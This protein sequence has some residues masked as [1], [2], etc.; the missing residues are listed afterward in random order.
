MVKAVT[1]YRLLSLLFLIAALALPFAKP[2][3]LHALE[4]NTHYDLI[5]PP[6]PHSG[7]MPTV[8]EVFNFKCSHCYRLHPHMAAW[9][10][11]NGENYDI[12]S[13]PIYWGKQ[14]DLPLRA[15]YAAEFLG[16]GE[17]MKAAIFKAQFENSVNIESTD[18]IG[19]LA[20]EVGLNPEKFKSFLNS[21]GVSA[22]I[23]QA[24]G[25]QRRFGVHSTPTLV[26]NGKYRVS[27]GKHANGDPQKLFN[28]VESLASR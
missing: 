11:L 10:K 26:I 6:V 25:Q 14:T 8:V 23:N 1:K 22:K 19:F 27:Y 4:A 18:E 21:F 9:S 17:E 13:L 20:E 2:G 24:K 16:K 5:T 3:Q 12:A 28:I 7:K 15:Y